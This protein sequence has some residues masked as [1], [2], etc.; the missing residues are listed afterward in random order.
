[1]ARRPKESMGMLDTLHK[2]VKMHG[3]YEAYFWGQ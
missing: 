2:Q 1:M 3:L